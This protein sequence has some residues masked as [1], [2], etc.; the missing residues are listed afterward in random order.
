MSISHKP[1]SEELKHQDA[2][3]PEVGR[4]VVA[5]VEDDFRGHV[6]RRPTER[7]RLPAQTNFFGETKINLLENKKDLNPQYVSWNY[8]S[9][10]HC[11]KIF[12]PLCMNIQAKIY[13]YRLNTVALSQLGKYCVNIA[14]LL[15]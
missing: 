3:G 5:L 6:L 14:I 15:S 12:L 11:Q 4:D 2:Q 13:K 7:P 9:V 10:N 8:V 1:A